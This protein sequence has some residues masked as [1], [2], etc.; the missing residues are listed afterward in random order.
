MVWLEYTR[1]ARTHA[2]RTFI[3]LV[4]TVLGF[5]VF[6]YFLFPMIWRDSHV[7]VILFFALEGLIF[8]IAFIFVWLNFKSS[9]EFVCR[10]D[11]GTIS[12]ICPVRGC[13]ETFTI[14]I[15]DIVK[16]ERKSSGESENWYIWDKQGRRYELTPN[17]GN[18]IKKFIGLIKDM[19]SEVV[20]DRT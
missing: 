11:D 13:G 16:I 15:A 5:A 1:A 20:E 4:L 17:Y 6:Q 18:P 19:N 3:H 12:Q 14:C 7:F 8:G 10:V 2:I 9:G